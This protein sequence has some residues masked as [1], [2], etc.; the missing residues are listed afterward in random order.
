MDESELSRCILELVKQASQ[1]EEGNSDMDAS[2]TTVD[3]DDLEYQSLVAEVEA[4][5][6]E[7][8]EGQVSLDNESSAVSTTEGV[9]LPNSKLPIHQAH[10]YPCL[11]TF[12]ELPS[13]PE[14]WPQR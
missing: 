11:D 14:K 7:F 8:L 2:E 6:I 3:A 4:K 12:K 1:D 13:P 10:A 5:L 9:D